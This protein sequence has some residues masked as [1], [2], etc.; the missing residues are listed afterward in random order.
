M[1]T[2]THYS[3]L[4]SDRDGC[5]D[6]LVTM[7]AIIFFSN[8]IHFVLSVKVNA[9]RGTGASLLYELRELRL[10]REASPGSA[11]GEG[12]SQVG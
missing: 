2:R 11:R 12:R 4:T 8:S 7:I 9:R 5:G 10:T 6:L 3:L 1:D